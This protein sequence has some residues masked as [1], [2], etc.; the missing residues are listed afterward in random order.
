M[1]TLSIVIPAYNEAERLP[2]TLTAIAAYLGSTGLDAEVIVVDDGSSDGTAEAARNATGVAMPPQVLRHEQNRA[3]GEDLAPSQRTRRLGG[4]RPH[5]GEHDVEG[6]GGR[7]RPESP[8]PPHRA[9][10]AAGSAGSRIEMFFRS[11]R[12]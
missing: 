2:P 11:T 8:G 3:V 7:D 4:R 12:K 6:E 1:V 9:A 5:R 10:A